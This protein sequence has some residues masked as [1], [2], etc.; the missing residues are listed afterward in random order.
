ML[1]ELSLVGARLSL[2]PN[3]EEMPQADFAPPDLSKR[4]DDIMDF[5]LLHTWNRSASV[6]RSKEYL[7]FVSEKQHSVLLNWIIRWAWVKYTRA[8]MT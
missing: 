7:T 8:L 1:G 2:E 4:A 3:I 5:F 6:G